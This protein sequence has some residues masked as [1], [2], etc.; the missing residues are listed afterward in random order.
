MPISTRSKSTIALKPV[1]KSEWN[2]VEALLMMKKTPLTPEPPK[3]R[4]RR[5]TATYTPGTFAGME[6]Q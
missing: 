5:S 6:E 2:A 4:P 3:Q 1:S